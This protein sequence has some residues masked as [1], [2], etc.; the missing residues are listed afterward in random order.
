MDFVKFLLSQYFTWYFF[1]YI[2]W[3]VN[4]SDPYKKYYFLKE[5]DEVF[6]MD[7]NKLL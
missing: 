7:K 4:I 1:F 6:Q 3:T 2:S 5:H